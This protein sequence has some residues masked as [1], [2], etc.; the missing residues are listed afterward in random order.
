[1]WS[2]NS[3]FQT[4]EESCAFGSGSRPLS[5]EQYYHESEGAD[6]IFENG[7][8]EAGIAYLVDVVPLLNTDL[9]G[10]RTS[11]CGHQLLQVSDG[12]ILAAAGHTK[13]EIV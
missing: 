1:M 11:L 5:V 10:T 12:V 13:G 4:V 7:Q 8:R 6:N 9:L 2:C 3:S